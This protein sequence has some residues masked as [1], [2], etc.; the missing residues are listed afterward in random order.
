LANAKEE[1]A[2]LSSDNRSFV[3]YFDPR[4]WRKNYKIYQIVWSEELFE[5]REPEPDLSIFKKDISSLLGG[6]V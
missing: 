4:R 3:L 5:Q 1:A 6:S 2:T